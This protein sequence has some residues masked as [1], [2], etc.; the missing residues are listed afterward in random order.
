[1]VSANADNIAALQ[2]KLEDGEIEAFCYDVGDQVVSQ[3]VAMEAAAQEHIKTIAANA[4]T[5]VAMLENVNS[6]YESWWPWIEGYIESL[7]TS[8]DSVCS[9]LHRLTGVLEHGGQYRC[10]FG[11]CLKGRPEAREKK[12]RPRHGTTQ[13]NL[14]PGWHGPIYQAGYG[15]R[16]R[17]MGGHEHDL[18]KAGTKWPI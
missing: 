7:Q 12:T 14:V 16:S 3:V 10:T 6:I 18:F 4:T 13:N 5:R 15:P 8:V 17:P 2:A 9:D 1:V 11:P